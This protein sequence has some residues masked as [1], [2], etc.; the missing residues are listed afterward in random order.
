MELCTLSICDAFGTILENS[1]SVNYYSQ[2]FFHTK[3]D[4]KEKIKYN[5][6]WNGKKN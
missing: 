5:D 6:S 1:Y 3:I 2:T 4:S